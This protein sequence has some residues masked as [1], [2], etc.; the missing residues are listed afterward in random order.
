MGTDITL[1]SDDGFEFAAYRAEPEGP[2]RG[3]IVVIQ[4]IFGVNAHIRDVTDRYAAA[5]YLAIAPAVFDRVERGVDL[6][7]TSEGMQ[8][9]IA[10]AR[11][12]GLDFAKVLADARSAGKHVASA[13]KG[14]IVGYCFGGSV[15]AAAC[16]QAADV[17]SAGSGYYGS[18]VV[19][20]IGQ[21][22]VVPLQLHLQ[23][24][25]ASHADTL[26]LGCTHYPFLKNQIRA[27]IGNSMNIIDTSDAVIRQLGRQLEQHQLQS[28]ADTPALY[29]LS[30]ANADTLQA[31]ASRLLQ[32]DVSKRKMSKQTVQI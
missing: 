29:L 6:D 26:V 32:T 25:I 21:Q 11:G 18:N 24:I 5:G 22:P 12:G 15:T 7:Y 13:G 27:L 31:M 8:A 2:A 30:T 17:F 19:N 20:M 23:P 1:T 3:G 14:G 10:I 4:E 28:L 16:I 9:G